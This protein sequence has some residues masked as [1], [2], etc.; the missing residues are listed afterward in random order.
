MTAIFTVYHFD[1]DNETRLFLLRNHV[2]KLQIQSVPSNSEP[3][4]SHAA[5]MDY[6]ITNS[7]PGTLIAAAAVCHRGRF[8]VK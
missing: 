7:F 3:A 8:H 1:T 2:V 6:V 5:A 4:H